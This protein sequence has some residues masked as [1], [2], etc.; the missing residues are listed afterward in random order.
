MGCNHCFSFSRKI[1]ALEMPRKELAI[2]R[3]IAG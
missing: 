2:Y 3:P 1:P